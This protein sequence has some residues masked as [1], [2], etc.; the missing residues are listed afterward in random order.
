MHRQRGSVLTVVVIAILI[1]LGY[2][3]RERLARWLPG[4]GAKNA[5]PALEVTEFDC[6]PPGMFSSAR[7]TVRNSAAEP[8]ALRAIVVWK[9]S[10]MKPSMNYAQVSP[11][12]LAPGASGRFEVQ[13]ALPPGGG[14]EC[15]LGGFLNPDNKH[16]EFTA[17][18]AAVRTF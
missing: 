13:R 14:G 10:G 12:T 7:G 18:S 11:A 15:R 8:V 1:A 5:A 16:L 4:M 3:Q 6:T 9:I 2:W 17:R